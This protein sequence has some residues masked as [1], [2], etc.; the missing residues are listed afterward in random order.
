VLIGGVL[1]V[2]SVLLAGGAA[3]IGWTTLNSPLDIDQDGEVLTVERGISMAALARGLH[4]RGL[5]AAPG[6]LTFYARISDKATRIQ[7]GEYRLDPGLSAVGLLAKLAAG[8]VV[9]HQFTI[10]EGWRFSELLTRLREHPAIAATEVAANDVMAMLG[11]VG[12]H[13]EGQFLP[14]TDTFPRGPR[15]IDVLEWA[16]SALDATLSEAWADRN[17]QLRLE[18]E[19]Q[20]LILA[21]IIEKETAIPSERAQ[22]SA[23]L[24]NRLAQ[25]MRLQTDPTVIYGLGDEFNG[26]LTRRDLARDTPYNT[27][28]RHGLPPTPIALTGAAAIFAA[29]Q[30]EASEA[31]YFVATGLDDRS[32]RFSTSLEEHNRAVREFVERMRNR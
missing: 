15:D 13:P 29:V 3:W 11:H 6:L 2:A 25:Q 20:A 26:N 17:D 8:E 32:H 19:Y 16:K 27:Y 5:L 4:E 14:D 12:L 31:L 30:P 22:I 18:N 23:V 21:S 9:L 10:I 24:H 7:A 1:V 28:T